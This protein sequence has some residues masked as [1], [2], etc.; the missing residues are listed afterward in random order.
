ME[1][2]YVGQPHAADFNGGIL[3]LGNSMEFVCVKHNLNRINSLP[4]VVVL[5]LHELATLAAHDA[6]ATTRHT[7]G[8][9]ADQY[10]LLELMTVHTPRAHRIGE[11]AS[12]Y[13]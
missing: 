9:A 12:Y 5:H 2:D 11:K 7:L 3:S 13:F 10:A 4:E 8:L 6:N 1:I